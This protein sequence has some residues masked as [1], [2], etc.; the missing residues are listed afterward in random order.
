MK[1]VVQGLG[2]MGASL[3]LCLN[4]QPQHQVI[5]V[6][7]DPETLKHALNQGIVTETAA[8]LTAVAS[9]A[10]VIILA[11]P[12]SGIIQAIHTLAELPLKPDVIITDTG[13]TKRDILTEVDEYLGHVAF[14]GGHAMAGT[15]L[16]GVTAANS[17]LYQHAPY[18][19][20]PNQ[21]GQAAL[22]KLQA[23]FSPLA[24]NFTTIDVT[25]HDR[26][27]AMISDVPHIAAF[28]LMNAAVKQ[29]GDA[30][31]FGQYVAGGFKDTT[32]IAAS[33]PKLW[34][35][36]L[37]SNQAAVIASNQQLIAELTAFNQALAAQDTDQLL[38]LIQSAQKARQ[39]L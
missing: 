39:N 1:I 18:F 36:V 13:S 11:T 3:A 7:R 24:A 35:D 4:A 28:A 20:I 6:D 8:Q 31:E 5:G 22:P 19:L 23:L 34:T 29:L 30:S 2:E 33:D 32:R 37:M 15:H 12:V 9:Q 14:I 27:M 21:K 38:R 17:Q 16:S 26:L 25:A 10:D